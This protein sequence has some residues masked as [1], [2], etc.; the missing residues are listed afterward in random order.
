MKVLMQRPT[1][2]RVALATATAAVLGVAGLS[3]AYG[4]A[5]A[6]TASVTPHQIKV[7]PLIRKVSKEP[8]A[9]HFGCQ[10][11][12]I[13]GSAGPRCYQPAQI[14]Q[15]YGITPLLDH[16]FNG[17]GRTIVIVD[18]FQNPYMQTD[19]S[20]FDS[21]F[22]LPDPAFTQIAPQGLTPFDPSDDNQ[23]GW[24]EEIT[25]DVEW[26]HAAAPGAKILLALAASNDDADILATTKYV[27]DHN[28]GD[29]IS[30]SFGEAETCMDP[31]LL[32]QQHLLFAEAARKGMTVFASS[33][34]SG[35]AQP[36]CDG[37]AAILSASTPA[38]DPVVTGVGGTTLNADSTTG[39]YI[40][41][42]AWTETLFGCNPPAVDLNDVNCSGGGF[43][44]IYAQPDY[45]RGIVDAPAGRSSTSGKAGTPRNGSKQTLSNANRN[46]AVRAAGKAP[47]RNGHK[48]FV[49]RGVPDVAYD[50]GV[51]GGVLTHCGIC[52][53]VL[54]LDPADPT[55]FFIFGGT[56]AG[57]PQWGGLAA[58]GDQLGHHRMGPINPALYAIARSRVAYAAAFHDVTTGNNDVVEIGTGYDAGNGWDAVTGLGTPK[59]SRLLP[60]LALL[61]S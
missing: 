23:V 41:E 15:A 32:A 6:A 8:N 51:N 56:S 31:T 57:T 16:G 13:D 47:S 1:R 34:D 11:R 33:G 22:G 59:A 61:T 4:G 49:G 28:L 26:A 19:L 17:N 42:T 54:G 21:T 40:G 24:A 46:A 60:A 30:Q 53:F 58:I 14:Q 48:P 10:D 18:A 37:T 7:N 9:A 55:I 12:P 5:S 36:S 43:S 52:N 38:S 44:T 20:I 3:A 39:T 2:L 27:V 29:V 35:A 25:L 50:A 45:Q